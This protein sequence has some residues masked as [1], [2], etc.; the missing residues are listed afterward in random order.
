MN[1]KVIPI[2]LCS[3]LI[4]QIVYCQSAAVALTEGKNTFPQEKIFLHYNS[5]FFLLGESIYYK[6]YCLNAQNNSVSDL[7]KIAYVELVDQKRNVIFKHKI[8]FQ[9]DT[10]TRKVITS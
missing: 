10:F 7:S 3:F 4:V 5:S 1:K 2:I 6:V 8:K 9:V